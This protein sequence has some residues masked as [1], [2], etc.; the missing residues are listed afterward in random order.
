MILYEW[1]SSRGEPLLAGWQL[2]PRQ[3]R[4]LRALLIQLEGVGYEMAAGKAEVLT[5][6]ER[7]DKKDGNE[8]PLLKDSKAAERLLEIL[9]DR[10]CRERVTIHIPG[11]IA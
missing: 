2:E 1:V 10:D 6:L 3:Q 11:G 7:V 4:Q 9:A 5:F 8:R